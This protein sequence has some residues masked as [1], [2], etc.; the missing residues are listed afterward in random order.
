[1]AIPAR[2]GVKVTREVPTLRFNIQ[3]QGLPGRMLELKQ[4]IIK[5]GKLSSSHIQIQDTAVS[6]VHAVI[7]VTPQGEVFVIDLGSSNGTYVNGE[8]ISKE[9]LKSGDELKLGQTRIFVTIEGSG[10]EPSMVT[11]P[12]G[13]IIVAAEAT[14]EPEASALARPSSPAVAAAS[15]KTPPPGEPPPVVASPPVVPPPPVVIEPPPEASAL[16][17]PSSLAPKLLEHSS[18][19]SPPPRPVRPEPAAPPASAPLPPP[20]S[21]IKPSVRAAEI[22]RA[23]EP[24]PVIPDP[25]PTGALPMKDHEEEDDSGRD[26]RFEAINPAEPL[27]E[28][29]ASIIETR[30][31]FGRDIIEARTFESSRGRSSAKRAYRKTS[32]VTIGP[33]PDCDFI[34]EGFPAPF[35]LLKSY[36]EGF[37]FRFRGTALGRVR[38]GDKDIDLS[39]LIKQKDCSPS[40]E[41]GT[42]EWPFRQ[43]ALVSLKV[44]GTTLYLRSVPKA[45]PPP[46]SFFQS[47]D[48]RLVLAFLGVA[49]FAGALVWRAVTW[50]ETPMA[51]LEDKNKLD[52]RLV[53][54]LRDPKEQERIAKIYGGLKSK[55]EE[56]EEPGGLKGKMGQSGLK[57]AQRNK[58]RLALQ[59]KQKEYTPAEQRERDLKKVSKLGA[60]GA[61]AKDA[62][63]R[64]IFAGGGGHG[65]S[66]PF[67]VGPGGG[68]DDM[69]AWG[70]LNDGPPGESYGTEGWGVGPGNGT[71]GG[72]MGRYVGVGRLATRGQF[73]GRGGKRWGAG[74]AKFGEHQVSKPKVI[75]EEPDVDG[76]G[77]TREIIQRVIRSHLHEIRYCYERELAKDKS[78][79][80]K[81]VV[82]FTILPSG[83]VHEA[84][85]KFSN[86]HNEDVVECMLSRVQRWQFPKP[87]KGVPVLVSYP[88]LFKKMGDD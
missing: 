47:I 58:N 16:A 84:G 18:S 29:L 62:N 51:L 46:T 44:G 34:V 13:K 22:P 23:P 49:V 39:D 73:G 14:A 35:L 30:L 78:L 82:K 87:K 83:R 53:S 40:D 15:E 74:P 41:A 1:M 66:S 26:R 32:R 76:G 64:E 28:L 50:P 27:S 20:A 38:L 21:F 60:L 72:G 75:M 63:L 54:F 5:I 86:M 3:P 55:K 43:G 45:P 70:G 8:K 52:D 56:K 6:R 7:E 24:S 31:A 71:G 11:E 69:T 68:P 79:G 42:F 9:K 59:G 2:E 88:F 12:T 65:P 37:V 80:G 81:V 25:G 48:Q 19:P 33:T 17:R 61:M 36:D 57:D 67:G 4:D 85:K 77:L 10:S